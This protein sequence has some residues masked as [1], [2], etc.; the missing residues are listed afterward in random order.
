M[1]LYI[2]TKRKIWLTNNIIRTLLLHA[3]LPLTFWVDALH[4]A[5]YLQNILPSQLL[6]NH[7]PTHRLYNKIPIY[8][9][10]VSSVVFFTPN[11]F[12]KAKHKLSPCSTP[13]IF[14]GFPLNH[15]GYCCLD[16]STNKINVSRHM[17][18]DEN[19]FPYPHSRNPIYTDYDFLS[20]TI[21]LS[22][23]S[24]PYYQIRIPTPLVTPTISLCIS[25]L[26]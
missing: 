15:R 9:T 23:F 16:I 11:L 22:S 18:F 1:S 13:C 25:N 3:S 5:T 10:S 26:V 19:T 8:L 14:L 6:A 24:F 21:P 7:S 20:S 2:L 12:S 17:T 4:M